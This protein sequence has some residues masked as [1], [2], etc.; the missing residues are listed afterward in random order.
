MGI[1]LLL[2]L[3]P[4]FSRGQADTLSDGFRKQFEENLD[5]LEENFA[6][7][8]QQFNPGRLHFEKEN[9]FY[10][11]FKELE[12]PFFQQLEPGAELIFNFLQNLPAGKKRMLVLAWF[13]YEKKLDEALADSNLIALGTHICLK[14]T[15]RAAKQ[16]LTN[17]HPS[18]RTGPQRLPIPLNG[19]LRPLY[20]HLYSGPL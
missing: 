5:Q 11:G 13:Q 1:S 8:E 6:W 18:A 19:L 12:F 17:L 4:I 20:W 3:F 9:E 14:K 2:V 10:E 7:M 16:P 15:S